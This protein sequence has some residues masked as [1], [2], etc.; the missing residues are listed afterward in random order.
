MHDLPRDIASMKLYFQVGRIFNELRARGI[1]EDAPLKV[2]DLTAFD[3]YHYL[4][5]DTVDEAARRLA[6]TASSHILDVGAGIGGPARHLAASTGCRVTAVELQPELNATAA[7]LTAR[8][9]LG[10]RVRHLE[11]DFLAHDVAAWRCDGMVSWLVFLHIG[12]R[13]ALLRQI[14]RALK[15]GSKVFIEDFH[16]RAELTPV[17]WRDIR[18][19]VYCQALPSLDEWREQFRD[20][21]FA[22]IEITDMTETWRPFVTGRMNSFRAEEARNVAVHGRLV[23]DALDEFYTTMD[24]LF[25]GGNLGGIRVVATSP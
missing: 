18:Q 9:G 25:G 22:D 15:P 24:R 20:A 5:T 12:D 4:G 19:Q 17:E 10:E 23:F 21:G 2:G 16:K 8:C 6:V 3:Q 11:G 7:G 14:R 13:A 1:A